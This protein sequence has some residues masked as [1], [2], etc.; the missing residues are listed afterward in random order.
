MDNL[1]L[2]ISNYNLKDLLKLFNISED[3]KESEIKE[4]KRIVLRM[5][6]DKSKLDPKTNVPIYIDEPAIK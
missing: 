1:D 6:P 5:H 4:A 3:L 2:E